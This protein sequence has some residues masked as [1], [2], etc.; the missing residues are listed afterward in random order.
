M[1][2][3][4]LI[5]VVLLFALGP[6]ERAATE[7]ER[8]VQAYSAELSEG[9]CHNPGQN[10]DT[11]LQRDIHEYRTSPT[12]VDTSKIGFYFGGQDGKSEV[13]SGVS[14]GRG[15]PGA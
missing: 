15:T 13:H 7:Y 11:L 2:R 1:T 9:G 12:T 3:L 4:L 6:F 5:P 10:R 8:A 14:G